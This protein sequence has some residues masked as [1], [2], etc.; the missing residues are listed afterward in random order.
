VPI[1]HEAKILDIDPEATERLILDHGGTR[2]GDKLMRRYVYDITPGDESKWIRLRDAG[3]EATLAVKHIT[4]D[5]IDG[6]HEVEVAVDDFESTNELLAML[7]FT[8]KSYQEN[9]RTSFVLDSVELEIDQW[10][11]IPPYL[12]IEGQSR[13]DVVRVAALLGYSEDHRAGLRA[14]LD[15]QQRQAEPEIA[16]ARNR[17]TELEQERRR[18]ARG[19]V[20]GSIPED[21]AHE[22]QQRI[23][24]ELKQAERVLSTAT[25]VFARIEATLNMALELVDR[26]GELYRCTSARVRRL[27]NQCLFDQLQVDVDED[28]VSVTD[29][30]LKEPWAT[31]LAGDFQARMAAI[32]T[33]VDHDFHDRRS[34]ESFLVPPAG[35]E[36]AT[37]RLEVSRSIR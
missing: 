37:K 5:A 16:Y 33:N 9:R 17:V 1:E 18:L 21:L 31:L 20:T 32:T 7:G 22:E 2:L 24:K 27:L 8:P 6:T 13:D 15:K 25:M 19:V 10:P 14:E 12:E 26:C 11:L 35:I 4:S 34:K 3:G 30:K 36:P 29:A 23:T 28:G